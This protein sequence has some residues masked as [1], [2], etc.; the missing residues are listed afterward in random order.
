MYFHIVS[1]AKTL[2]QSFLREVDVL[3]ERGKLAGFCEKRLKYD[4]ENIC[5]IKP[6]IV[7][8]LT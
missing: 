8:A 7:F 6:K 5:Y 4:I 1:T 2:Q 3:S